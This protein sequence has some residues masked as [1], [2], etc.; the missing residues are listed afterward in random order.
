MVALTRTLQVL[1]VEDRWQDA[2]L[3]S[4][5]VRRAGIEVNWQ[6]VDHEEDYLIHLA[7]K[8]DLILADYTLPT[9]SAIRA[10]ELLQ[11]QALD[12]PFIVVTGSISEEVAVECMKL[13]AADYLLKDRLA[14]L[15]RAMLQALEEKRLRDEKRQAEAAL[16]AS[17]ERYR[18][19][20]EDNQA[21]KL[22]IDPDT[23]FVVDANS[24]ACNFYGYSQ[25][26]LTRKKVTEIAT[27]PVDQFPNGVAQLLTQQAGQ[28]SFRQ[29]LASGESCDVEVY[30]S[31]IDVYGGRLLFWIMHDITERK[32]LEA[33]QLQTERMR[34]ELEKERE[35]LQLKEDFIATVSHDFRTPLAV[36][37]TSSDMLIRYQDRIPIQRQLDQVHSILNQ[38][39]FMTNLLD[40]VLFFSK[41]KAGKLDFNPTNLKL[42]QYC[43]SL[44]NQLQMNGSPAQQFHF[45]A[46]GDLHD[47][48]MDEK[49][50][51]R[52]LVNLISNAIKYSPQG[53]EVRFEVRREGN[54]VLFTVSDQGVG[55]PLQDQA[56]LFEPF[57]RASNV[58]DI[59]GTGLGLAIVYENVLRHRGTIS[60]VS[61]LNRGTTFTVHLP[62]QPPVVMK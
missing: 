13:G 19:M 8:P 43:H 38:A 26:Q 51:Q 31:I 36:I 55:I 42:D 40:D 24:A 14:R 33:E 44:F 60:V 62:Y 10:L 30:S 47:A 23:S 28:F 16:R 21:I 3:I 39:K 54:E 2:E 15:G 27:L 53:G 9:F 41:A 1:M 5:E 50:L 45:A 7:L 61:E 59:E 18:Q 34:I 11:A 48:V 25:A 46:S 6:R 4:H 49:I 56:H 20:F 58:R 57:H 29:Q 17:E 12:I 37:M 32:R 35:L 22:L 52:V